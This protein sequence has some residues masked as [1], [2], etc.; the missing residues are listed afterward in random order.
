MKSDSLSQ[1]VDLI[2]NNSEKME[3]LDE[4]PYM[5]ID[6][7]RLM[8]YTAKP[9]PSSLIRKIDVF[10]SFGSNLPILQIT[11][12]KNEKSLYKIK[13]GKEAELLKALKDAGIPPDL[14]FLRP[15]VP[16]LSDQEWDN[17]KKYDEETEKLYQV[18]RQNISMNV[19]KN[20]DPNSDEIVLIDI[21]TGLGDCLDVTTTSLHELGKSIRSIGID[22]S[23]AN[24]TTANKRF[25][26]KNYLFIK[27]DS[28]NVEAFLNRTLPLSSEPYTI[29]TASGSLTREVLNNTLEAHTIL[30][31]LLRG[32]AD[33]VV[34]GGKTEPLVTRRIAKKVGWNCDLV[35]R[36]DFEL[37]GIYILTPNPSYL[38]KIKNN[39]LDLSLHAH[40]L[41]LLEK[42]P[43][44]DLS[45]IIS[46]DLGL[47]YLRSHEVDQLL[48]LCPKL[49]TIQIAGIEP[50]VKSMESALSNTDIMLSKRPENYIDNSNSNPN[51]WELKK[52]SSNFYNR[53][54][55]SLNNKKIDYLQ[56]VIQENPEIYIWAPVV[57]EHGIVSSL[58]ITSRGDYT[59]ENL[60]GFLKKLEF[61][62][63]EGDYAAAYALAINYEKG[64]KHYF[65]LGNYVGESNFYDL[66]KSLKYFNLL[67]EKGYPV[68]KD[69]QR[70]QEKIDQ[71]KTSFDIY[72]EVLEAGELDLE[73]I[74]SGVEKGDL[75]ESDRVNAEEKFSQYEPSVDELKEMVKLSELDLEQIESGLP[76]DTEDYIGESE[77]QDNIEM[78]EKSSN[79]N[80][81]ALFSSA[82]NVDSLKE[83]IQSQP[84]KYIWFPIKTGNGYVSRV[85]TKPLF[86]LSPK[87]ELD[88]HLKKLEAMAFNGDDAAAY[89]LALNYEK[90]YKYHY[91]RHGYVDCTSLKNLDKSLKYFLLLQKRGYPMDQDVQRVQEKV[92]QSKDSFTYL[93]EQVEQEKP[94]QDEQ[95][96]EISST[97]LSD[98]TP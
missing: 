15:R 88:N 58:P 8:I 85:D 39:H 68:E 59:K 94:H 86:L 37:A 49:K 97:N 83:F 72:R 53:Y 29:I 41:S 23:E 28:K 93:K 50:W 95:K 78:K 87:N 27:E 1:L 22:T 73:E 63:L 36:S 10:L 71:N 70:V 90:G 14:A 20:I 44:A 16:S 2:K 13:A 56:R 77:E 48:E 62:A 4:I 76:E 89:T 21:G 17:L 12:T 51:K 92:D 55:L 24:I 46:I 43:K 80:R 91:Y 79:L 66:D 57:T 67:F 61:M 5:F 69:I 3:E 19:L 34:I 30:Q 42:Y 18:I 81:Y 75:V 64:Y 74:D 9:E 98:K 38:P 96:N 65:L 45:K 26:A 54:F 82:K 60:D 84:E 6:E 33:L 40:P 52:T 25:S 31:Q 35:P 47:S 32:G 7:S 11:N